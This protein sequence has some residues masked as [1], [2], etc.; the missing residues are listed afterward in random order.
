MSEL[1]TLLKGIDDSLFS[2]DK[3][4][5]PIE[6]T[7]LFDEP[8]ANDIAKELLSSAD[9]DDRCSYRLITTMEKLIVEKFDPQEKKLLREYIIETDGEVQTFSEM[10]QSILLKDKKPS[11]A[12]DNSDIYEEAPRRVGSSVIVASVFILL[13]GISICFHI[14]VLGL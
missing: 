6:G 9:Y 12:Y 3:A 5:V 10:Q 7:P 13:L 14:F 4:E 1:D 2:E 11:L 8:I